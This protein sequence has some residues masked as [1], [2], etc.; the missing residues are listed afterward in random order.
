[1]TALAA[2]GLD[3]EADYTV[4]ELTPQNGVSNS[5][6]YDAGSGT[7]TITLTNSYLRWLKVSLDQYGPDG[8]PIGNTTTLGELSPVD[9]IMAVP[10][11]PQP[12][13]FN[14]TFNEQASSGTISMGG[15]GQPPYDWTHD[16][17]GILLT[18]IFNFAIPTIFIALGVA[19]DQGGSAWTDLTKQVVSVVLAAL[20]AAAEGPIGSAVAGGVSTEDLLAAIANCAGSLLL[21]VLTSSEQL[22]AYITAAAGESAAEDAAPFV[23]WIARAIGSA[24]DL[25]SMT[26]TSVEVARCP[27]TMQLSVL[28][29]MDVSVT[30]DPDPAHQGQWPATATHYVITITYDDGPTYSCSGQMSSTTQQ[31]PIYHQTFSGLPAGGQHHR[32][33]GLLFR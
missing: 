7:A 1:M 19:V 10:L 20:E 31:G 24:A 5:F 9:T 28:R 16:G 25:A 13:P 2:A 8:E 17:D 23:G 27:A 29:T 6:A 33:S 30:V 4:K 22:T 11:S 18:S 14:F 3:A 32:V 15:I 21:G 12:S 26:E